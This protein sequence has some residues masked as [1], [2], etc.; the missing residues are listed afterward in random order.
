ME[1]GD[2]LSTITR[3]GRGRPAMERTGGTQRELF[4]HFK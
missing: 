4:L 2:T 3:E 1:G